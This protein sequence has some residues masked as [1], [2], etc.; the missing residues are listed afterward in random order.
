MALPFFY[1][2]LYNEAV[3]KIS[4]IIVKSIFHKEGK[5]GMSKSINDK[6]TAFRKM[7]LILLVLN[8]IRLIRAA[9]VLLLDFKEM[10]EYGQPIMSLFC[11]LIAIMTAIQLFQILAKVLLIKS[12]SPT[13]SW[14]SGRKGYIV[15]AILL[16]L[17]N[18]GGLIINLL[19]TGGVGATLFN[20]LILC[21][22]VLVSAVEIITVFT[23]L[24]MVKK[25]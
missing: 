2:M 22:W 6:M 3:I 17:F 15:A 21:L 7:F 1:S 23:Y 20:Q 5:T 18:F 4:G 10:A 19:S 13:F 24:R 14:A 25:L 9:I 11:V 8:I 16:L 12:T